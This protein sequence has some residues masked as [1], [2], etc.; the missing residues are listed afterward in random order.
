MWEMF[1]THTEDAYSYATVD[2]VNTLLVYEEMIKKDRE[3]YK[4]FGIPDEKV[5]RMRGTVGSRV[6]HFLLET[7]R[8]AAGGTLTGRALEDLM[9][10]G[11]AAQMQNPLAPSKFGLQTTTV[12]GGLLFN[13][14]PTRFW[15]ESPG[16]LRDVDLTGCFNQI[17]CGLSVYWGR[18]V[19]FEPGRRA[20]TLREAVEFAMNHAN[21]DAWLIRVS[22]TI[23]NY[24]NALIPSTE[25]A[26]TSAEYR[27][28]L[29]RGKRRASQLEAY[30]LERLQD[31]FAVCD[32]GS[33]RL[34]TDV[35]VS[36][37]VTL[38]TWQMIQ[39]LPHE[40]R[41]TYENLTVDTILVYPRKF[42]AA[43]AAEY[44]ELV[45]RHHTD[46]LPWETTIDLEKLELTQR[47]FLDADYVSLRYQIGKYAQKIGEFRREAQ[48]TDGKGSGMDL[49]WK[50]Q[51]NTMY[52]VLNSEHSPT[53]NIIAANQITARARAMAFA[54][55]Q[56]LNAIQTIT[57]G[58]SY[59]KDQIP[60]C[61]YAECLRVQ[62]DYPIKRA[63][64]NGSMAFLDPATVPDDD[65][66][67]TVWLRGHLARFFEIP[68]ERV[69][70]LFGAHALEHK[71]TVASAAFDALGC[72][73]AGN[74]LKCMKRED[75]AW[76]VTAFAARS[77]GTNSKAILRDTLVKT[78]STDSYRELLPITLD[79]ELM[80]LPKA[81]QKAKRS[82]AS[83][84]EE[85]LLPLG[86]RWWRVLTYR[87]V[88]LSAFLFRTPAQRAKILR[89][90]QRFEEQTG[91]GLEL[92]ALRRG[93]RD[94]R[95]GSLA[96]Q[97]DMV[98]ES[99]RAGKTSL[100][101]ALNMH[102]IS[103]EISNMCAERVTERERL[104]HG[105]D[106]FLHGM[107][108]RRDHQPHTLI[109]GIILTEA[110]SFVLMT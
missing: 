82:L 77:Y 67:F 61:T 32:A 74:Y 6:S 79:T 87:I 99:V 41:F 35:I 64:V 54:M 81:A 24:L 29:R 3:I 5:G 84:A 76:D 51:A 26:F 21:P 110:D 18:P 56:A 23:H 25:E 58:C 109:T 2:V 10:Q 8:Q 63:E 12:H 60:A 98:Y 39:A 22:G 97:A 95:Q 57:D 37:V 73:G 83:G 62:P 75:G 101:S 27:T 100:A 53:Q 46:A 69:D 105:A 70:D 9:R 28:R 59:R 102:K 45:K 38:A 1:H 91:C 4:S 86:Y 92:L 65:A 13:R 88:K 78:Y 68:E 55:S 34:Y 103:D 49:A 15:H 47:Q 106:T 11:G 16:M 72:D 52:G 94:R 36:G 14:S 80:T 89:Q 85:V 104:R 42:V 96:D 31:P 90:V 66:T 7:V 40:V 50:Q 43:D 71:K 108:D 19:L 93:Y 107:I 17:I 30:H 48:R 33:S 20:L 44:E